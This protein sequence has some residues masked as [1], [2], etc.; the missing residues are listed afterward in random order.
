M[1]RDVVAP[2]ALGGVAA[3][4]V[5][6]AEGRQVHLGQPASRFD[7]PVVERQRIRRS[8]ARQRQAPGP[9]RQAP[10]VT[11]PPRVV[12]V[13][14][15]QLDDGIDVAADGFAGD[16]TGARVQVAAHPERQGLVRR[17]ALEGVAE[18]DAPGVLFD[19]RGEPPGHRVQVGAGD[20]QVA[21]RGLEVR[22]DPE[23]GQLAQDR[24]VGGREAV[25][26]RRQQAF[27]RVGKRAQVAAG[28]DGSGEL[29]QQ[30][31]VAGGALHERRNR[32]RREPPA[33][34]DDRDDDGAGGLVGDRR[35]VDAHRVQLVCR[36]EAARV[37]AA[38]AHDRAG[39]QLPARQRRLQ[40]LAR[41]GVQPVGVLDDDER[42]RVEQARQQPRAD[43][44]PPAPR[45]LG[46][47]PRRACRQR[48]V[49]A[50]DRAEQAEPVLQ[51]GGG[52]RQRIR[53][54]RGVAVGDAEQLAQRGPRGGVR[55]MRAVGG[56]LEADDAQPRVARDGD[57]V[58]EQAR[59]ADARRAAQLDDGDAPRQRGPGRG[60]ERRGLPIAA[61][62]HGEVAG[63]RGD[64]CG[65]GRIRSDDDLGLDEHGLA[66]DLERVH[67]LR[68]EVPAG[69]VQDGARPEHVA[70]GRLAHDARREVR[71]VAH[72]RVRPAR[73]RPDVHGEDA[74]GVDAGAEGERPFVRDDLAHREQHA[75]GIVLVRDGRAGREHDLAGRE[76]GVRADERHAVPLAGLLDRRHQPVERGA[77]RSRPVGV[78]HLVDALE[79]DEGDDRLTV[80]A[81]LGVRE[82]VVQDRGQ[83]AERVGE[84]VV[85]GGRRWPGVGPGCQQQP[86]IGRDRAVLVAERRDRD[87]VD[88]D[89]GGL[90]DLL[91]L[92]AGRDRRPGD[93]QLV[94]RTAGA[95]QVDRPG[96]QPRRRLQRD[97]ADRR[98]QALE[99]RHADLQVP[100][101]GRAARRVAVARRGG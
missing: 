33:G 57:R 2:G 16:I 17:R 45:R 68:L 14:R 58:R 88:E 79:L 67:R 39:P 27:D 35:E 26:R 60:R 74:P 59:L 37:G 3:L 13:Q 7:R 89:L 23:H 83:P 61:G 69:P 42:R 99:A 20:V 44:P 1:R 4:L 6:G 51:P 76:V 55:R 63:I 32:V 22:R 30:Q 11:Q 24:A 53:H 48:K 71:R 21:R 72:R 19:E 85:M 43:E 91:E 95:K 81:E 84:Q 40:Q 54:G 12:G 8:A 90:G 77:D 25:D 87:G 36:D 46:V 38:P 96:R 9:P 52:A 64:L 15:E 98:A 101:R 31:G 80:L 10:A 5:H 62:R 100:G 78:E 97:R 49:D 65:R 93:D 41:R 50:D 28:A 47:Q 66:L 34:R 75:I 94:E 86:A 73:G 92:Q 29:A 18:A 82:L 56:P 70:V